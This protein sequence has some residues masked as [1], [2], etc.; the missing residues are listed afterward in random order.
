MR[1]TGREKTFLIGG[2]CLL[3]AL[4]V[5]QFA[6]YP[7]YKRTRE[8]ERLIPQKERDLQELRLLKKEF[9]S[10]KEMRVARVQ[11]IPPGERA[12]APLSKLEALIERSGLRQ[13]IRSI[14]PS[15]SGG[16]SPEAMTVEV[17]IEKADLP[18]MSRF[19]YEVQSSPGGFRIARMGIKPR[20]TTPRY[21]DVTLEMV[22][23]QG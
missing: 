15:P 11:K 14:K 7:A 5:F 2:A 1:I 6:F 16:A 23:Y 10:L 21:L 17:M 22:F 19:L 20:Y 18:R 4:L 8:L 3:G 9:D 13:N 12:L